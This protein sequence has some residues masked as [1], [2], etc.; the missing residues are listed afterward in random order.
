MRGF[1]KH[2][3]KRTWIKEFIEMNNKRQLSGS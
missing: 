2:P 1:S 3:Y